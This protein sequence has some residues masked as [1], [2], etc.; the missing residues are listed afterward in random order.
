[1]DYA[2]AVLT[3]QG[4]RLTLAAW[5][6]YGDPREVRLIKEISASVSTNRVYRLELEDG[7]EFVAKTSSYGSY[8]HFRQDHCII[9]EWI[10]LLAG[11]RYENLLARIAETH[12]TP[13]GRGEVFI[14]HLPPAFVAFYHRA[15][16]RDF[17]P[18][19]LSEAQIES[20]GQEMALLHAECTRIAP[21]LQPTWKSVGSDIAILYDVAGSRAWL[22]D[23]GF[24]NEAER[25]IKTQCERFLSQAELLGYHEMSRIPV[26]V[27]WNPG[28]FSVACEGEHFEL[29]TRWD[30]DWFRVEPRLFDLYFCSRVVRDSGDET[31]FSYLPDTLMEPRFV[32]FL[33]A[34]RRFLPLRERDILF[35]KETYRFL[36]LNYVIRSGEHFFRPSICVRLQ[37][38]ALERYLPRI[39]DLS[40]EPLCEAVLK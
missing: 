2:P 37:K 34:Y 24:P 26:L 32:Q 20:F 29:F 25:L 28:N 40:L 38:E 21:R 30:Y 12:S 31:S 8:V 36:I 16:Y 3:E 13:E 18:R 15:P 5:K 10:D 9:K 19:R 22:R 27:D 23:R 7:T 11:T 4:R 39:D 14:A 6:A 1:M 33:R 35:I 17:L